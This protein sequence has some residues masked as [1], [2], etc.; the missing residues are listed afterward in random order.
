MSVSGGDVSSL[1]NVPSPNMI[2]VALSPDGSE[3]LVIDA[4]GV[5]PAGPLWALPILGGSPRRLSEATGEDA[6]WS[7]DGSKLAYTRAGKVFVASGN[8]GA[9]RE[10]FSMKN[11]VLNL[12]WSPDGKHLR[13]DTSEGFDVGGQ[14][15]EWE[16]SVDGTDLHQLFPGWH[17]PQ[18]ECCG[19]WTADGRF[20]V[21]Q[22]QNQIWALP[23]QRALLG[24]HPK[25]IQLTSSPMSLYSPIPGKD[26]KKLFVVGRSYR[27][28]LDRYDS[29][30]GQFK[31]YLEGISAE[32][33]DF[34]KDGQWVAYTSFPDGT[35]WRSKLDGSER[36]QLTYAP[37]YA[38][39]P[40]WSPDGTHIV[41]FEFPQ[42]SAKPARMYILPADGGNPR[43]LLPDD[44][45]HQQD[46]NWSP[47]GKTII[48]AGDANDA[49]NN[50]SAP[51][52]RLLDLATNQVSSLPGSQNLFSPRWSPDGKYILAMSSDSTTLM[53]FNIGTRQWTPIAKGSFGWLSWSRNGEYVYM[54]DF[55]GKGAVVRVRVA[56]HKLEQIANLKNF[57]L[58]GRFGGGLSLAPD[59][60]PLLLRDT[61]TQDVYALDWRV[62]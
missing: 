31:P 13:F 16:V 15:V 46:P 42:G 41:F 54:L 25:P 35:I 4:Q 18:D 32:Y 14:H 36:R 30:S 40:R 49:A 62:R 11:Q 3:L 56:D 52:I 59:D 33:L 48:F 24:S 39:M 57:I 55:S 19:K 58:T 8:G 60:S 45:H 17:D 51:S 23:E 27:G 37:L 1:A 5:P 44:P 10:L 12:A 50:G 20:F 7:A 47:D 28:Q 34:S 2:P 21:F 6:A 22:S 9:S 53:L 38:V 43:A 61:G 29:K 26:G